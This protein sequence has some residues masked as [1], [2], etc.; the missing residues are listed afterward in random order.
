VVSFPQA[1]P[2]TP[3]AHPSPPPYAIEELYGTEN[4]HFH[5]YESQKPRQINPTNPQTGKKPK[6]KQQKIN[7]N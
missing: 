3:C 2:P 6:N 5:D 4:N 1:Y 7:C